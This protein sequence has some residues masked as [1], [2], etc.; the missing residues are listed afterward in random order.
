M[1]SASHGQY[2]ATQK[3]T[4]EG[5]G[6]PSDSRRPRIRLWVNWTLAVLTVPAAVVVVQR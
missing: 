5:G 2:E 1:T 6:A 4:I 3:A